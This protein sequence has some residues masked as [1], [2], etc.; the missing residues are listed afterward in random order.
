MENSTE[1]KQPTAEFSEGNAS[2]STQEEQSCGDG[3]PDRSEE[4][5]IEAVE[6]KRLEEVSEDEQIEMSQEEQHAISADEVSRLLLDLADAQERATKL[7][8][9]RRL[10]HEQLLRR[11][12][13]FENFRKRTERERNEI[14]L[15]ARAELINEMLPILDNFERALTSANSSEDAVQ[16]GILAGIRLIHRQ[17]LDCLVGMGLNPIKAVGEPF[18]PHLHEAVTTEVNTDHP[19]SIIL[20]ELRRGY[21]LGDKLIRPSMVKV[22]VRE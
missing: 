4:T 17:F 19:E 9:E 2:A 6:E 16:E 20:E 5:P 21:K 8:E 3:S 10:L 13:E 1:M 7:A 22:S 11:Q 12:A 15:K 14:A 18:D